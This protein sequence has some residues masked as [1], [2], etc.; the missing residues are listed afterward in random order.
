MILD[1]FRAT[2]SRIPIARTVNYHI[3]DI[4][5]SISK[6]YRENDEWGKCSCCGKF[7]RF[8]YTK[9]FDV[10]SHVAT[11]DYYAPEHERSLLWSDPDL[12]SAW[13]IEVE[14][15]LS[16]KDQAGKRLKKAEV[17]AMIYDV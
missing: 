16:A 4:Y 9:Y 1:I 15:I 6:K 3:Q 13:P 12:A 17:F 8:K 14:P 10:S 5:S 2:A 7:T 11:T